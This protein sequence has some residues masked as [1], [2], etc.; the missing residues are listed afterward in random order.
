MALKFSARR[1]GMF[2]TVVKLLCA[3]SLCTV[4]SVSAAGAG[5][6]TPLVDTIYLNG[7]I[8]TMNEA[9]DST[10]T[11][12]AVAVSGD[13]ITAVGSADD[14][15]KMA[16][17]ETRVVDLKGGTMFPGFID[18]HSHFFYAAEYAYG[19]IDLNSPPIGN[20]KSID[21]MI[22]LLKKKAATTPK[23]EWILGWGYDD[24]NIKD[25]RHPTRED[26]DKVSTEHPIFIQHISG[27]L[28]SANSLALEKAG[29]TKDTPDPSGGRILKDPETGEPTGVIES[30]SLPVLNAAPKSTETDL[31]KA[32]KSGSEMYLAAGCTTAQEGWT[33][34]RQYKI[35]KKALDQGTLKIRTIVWPVSQGKH[36][37]DKGEYPTKISGESVDDNHMLVYGA[38][39]LTA[40]GSIQGYTGY[41]TNPYQ[42]QQEGK[43]GYR[44]YPTHPRK[45][46]IDMVVALHQEGRQ[47]AIHGNGD[48]AIDDILDA[49]EIAQQTYPRADARHIVVHSQMVREDQLDRMN[50]L[51]AIP[52][53][54]VTHTYFWGDRHSKIFMGP[55][56]AVRMS[57]VNSALRR[58]MRFTLHNDTYVTPI[59]PLMAVWSAVNRKSSG[60]MDMGK[61]NQGISQYEA[62]KGVTIHAAWQGFEEKIKGSIETGKLADFVVLERNPLTVDPLQIKDIKVRATIIGNKVAHGSL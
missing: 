45:K 35:L 39:K 33:D 37:K 9:L 29:I 10:N 30:P 62:L 48:A 43:I 18:P 49:L 12:E 40:D 8:V 61:D 54:F 17:S 23:G 4:T 3:L 34:L 2:Q 47:I 55:D 38:S 1:P 32:M 19:W 22:N 42:Q 20:V 21:E 7:K 26:L 44:G 15:K 59:S 60:G 53:F 25:M 16:N 36:A 56:R 6:E 52:S 24:T 41:L 58:G 28:S 14:I 27:W 51:G 13:K 5:M 57:P 31:I 46:L 50:R 11:V